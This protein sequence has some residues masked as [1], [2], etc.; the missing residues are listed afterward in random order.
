LSFYN[1]LI[2]FA[3]NEDFN[4]ADLR[5]KSWIEESCSRWRKKTITRDI[6]VETLLREPMTAFI[7]SKMLKWRLVETK[8]Q[9]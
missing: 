6:E 2:V 1:G 3:D 5:V 9:N 4:P 7:V 8:I